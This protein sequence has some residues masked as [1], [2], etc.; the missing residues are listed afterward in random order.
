MKLLNKYK[1]EIIIVLLICS[2]ILN[3]F[4]AL[5]S[6]EVSKDD[7]QLIKNELRREL[8]EEQKKLSQQKVERYEQEIKS[9]SVAIFSD[10]KSDSVF[11]EWRRRNGY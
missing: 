11:A 7:A 1:S 2:I 9:D 6:T 4:N 10:G 3:V 5:K 8:I